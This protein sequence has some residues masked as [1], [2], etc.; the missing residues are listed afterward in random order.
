[1]VRG[2]EGVTM[3]GIKQYSLSPQAEETA[4]VRDWK[5]FTWEHPREG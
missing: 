4:S 5:Q 2:D 1:M 3:G